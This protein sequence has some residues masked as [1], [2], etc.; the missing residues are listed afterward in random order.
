[1]HIL[2]LAKAAQQTGS[3]DDEELVRHI[4]C[5]LTEHLE[6][7]ISMEDVAADLHIGY[8]RFR[9]TFKEKPE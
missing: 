7:N 3:S 2:A 1:V 6:R 8:A 9:R 5:A 4:R